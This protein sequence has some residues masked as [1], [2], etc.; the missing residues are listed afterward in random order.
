M[1]KI[2]IDVSVGSDSTTSSLLCRPSACLLGDGGFGGWGWRQKEEE[3]INAGE[4]MLK[5]AAADVKKLSKQ[6]PNT[7]PKP[8]LSGCVCVCVCV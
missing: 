4:K 3:E 8:K 7:R 1:V 6:F 2:V 5:R